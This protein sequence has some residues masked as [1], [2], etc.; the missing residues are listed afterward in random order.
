MEKE[1]RQPRP[2]RP[3]NLSSPTPKPLFPSSRSLPSHSPSLSY[4]RRPFDPSLETIAHVLSKAGDPVPDVTLYG[5]TPGDEIKLSS[6][7]KKIALFA[8]PGAFTPTCDKSH[9][10]GAVDRISE[11]KAAGADAVVF[12]SVNDPFVMTAW[13]ESRGAQ[14][15][16]VAM[17]AD[18][19]CEFT[20]ALG[21]DVVLDAEGA[22]GSK[23]SKRY[24][25]VIVDGKFSA[26]NLEA[27]GTGLAC[28][29]A[30]DDL[31]KQLKEA[32]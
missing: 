26:F 18:P 14:K 23:R 22:L 8:V 17:L 19:R 32:A 11:L 13:G 16:G 15:A 9:L 1:E 31:V 24:S 12:V 6:L 29:A 25:A 27:D 3:R 7:G 28:S 20:R 5:A 10:P 2:L 21:D 30:G 4:L